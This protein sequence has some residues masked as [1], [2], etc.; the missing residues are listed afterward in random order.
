MLVGKRTGK[1]KGYYKNGQ[2][3]R[4]GNSLNDKEEGEWKYYYDTGQLLKIEYY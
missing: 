1:W 2:L 3:D 4:I